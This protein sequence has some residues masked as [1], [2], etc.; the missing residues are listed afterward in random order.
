MKQRVLPLN[1]IHVDNEWY[2]PISEEFKNLSYGLNVMNAVRVLYVEKKFPHWKTITIYEN[3]TAMR[4]CV[5]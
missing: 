2:M 1:R 5:R 4:G 3:G